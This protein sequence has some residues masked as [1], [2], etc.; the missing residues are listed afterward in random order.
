MKAEEFVVLIP[1]RAGSLGV[2]AKNKLQIGPW[3][4][5]Y[6]SVETAKATGLFR[7]DQILVSSDDNEILAHAEK[8]GATPIRRPY[9]LA[10][11]AA[12]TESVMLHALLSLP[13]GVKYMILLQP[14]SPIRLPGTLQRCMEK[15]DSPDF[16]SLLT[17]TEFDL[18]W[19]RG[20]DCFGWVPSYNV[21][22]RPRRQEFKEDDILCYE[23]GNIYITPVEVLKATRC[24]IGR[25]PY[26]MTVSMFESFQ[27]DTPDDLANIRIML[28]Q[29]YDL[30]KGA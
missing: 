4:L 1:A 22:N 21:V 18:H 20:A 13:A 2:V 5:Y 28:A 16:D 19:K 25:R 8:N 11:D 26:L 30:I 23:N 12:S 3:P 17:V 14:T 27:L 10:T 24:R 6:H 29:C 7:Q 15:M 9:E